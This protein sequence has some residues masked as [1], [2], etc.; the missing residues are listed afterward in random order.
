MDEFEHTELAVL[1]ID[2]QSEEEACVA[3]IHNFVVPVL[4]ETSHLVV[5]GDDLPVRLGLNFLALVLVVADV[6]A[7][8]SRFPLPILKEYETYLRHSQASQL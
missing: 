4:Q 7:T 1:G 6:P 8:K 2:A 5:S 3:P